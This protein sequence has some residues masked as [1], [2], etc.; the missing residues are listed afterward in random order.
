MKKYKLL[1]C[2]IFLALVIC[3]ITGCGG[4]NT[5]MSKPSPSETQQP[6]TM[7]DIPIP[8][9]FNQGYA[10]T[11]SGN[12]FDMTLN[13][14]FSEGYLLLVHHSESP[15]YSGNGISMGGTIQ[16][17]ANT[18]AD[19]SKD[20]AA[21]VKAVTAEELPPLPDDPDA[22][23]RAAET[24]AMVDNYDFFKKI[25]KKGIKPRP[26]TDEELR[27]RGKLDG[28]KAASDKVGQK[29]KFWVTY[30]TY[31]AGYQ[32]VD[33]T[34]YAAGD[35]CY[36]YIE[37]GDT[38]LFTTTN[39]TTYATAI[40]DYFDAATYTK[41]RQYIGKEWNPGIDGDAR[42]YIILTSHMTVGGYYSSADEYPQSVLTGGGFTNKSNE[43]EAVYE[44]IGDGLGGLRSST[45]MD[46]VIG[47]EFTHMVYYASKYI[48]YYGNTPITDWTLRSSKM[49]QEYTMN[50]GLAYFT[51]NRLLGL[52][53][54]D[55]GVLARSM[56][57]VVYAYL[58]Q[59]G[60]RP[61]FTNLNYSE[62]DYPNH[63]MGILLIDYLYQ[64]LG[65]SVIAQLCAADDA[66]GL[67]SCINSV[68]Y[69]HTVYGFEN[70]FDM[71]AMTM[72]LS[73]KVND[74]K[75]TFTTADLTGATS[76][77]GTTLTNGISRYYTG[78]VY[79][80]VEVDTLGAVTNLTNIPVYEWAPILIR[81]YNSN[82][83][84][85]R[86]TINI[87]TSSLPGSGSIKAYFFYK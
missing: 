70:L 68:N 66:T 39:I 27:E 30:T 48:F 29:R 56:A 40:A 1:L 25:E 87:M 37:D 69:C 44:N 55:N 10:G 11:V 67:A 2:V 75:Y 31:G 20:E 6:V 23:R 83:S 53:L 61:C 46:A 77:D 84:Q 86:L 19:K 50:E 51:E 45:Y 22:A 32:Q 76:Y 17:T 71:W 57:N 49:V 72:M 60:G 47:H 63:A 78:N 13:G 33:F 18:R 62:A 35:N 43:I 5:V 59:I 41:V 9:G 7:S 54:K 80:G 81:F 21:A 26:L 36:V 15:A 65:S 4:S 14:S 82:T 85:F 58:R 73:G 8:S 52:G 79:Q 24:K 28:S 34:C 3:V 64:M 16:K 38:G 74:S 42:V 12:Q